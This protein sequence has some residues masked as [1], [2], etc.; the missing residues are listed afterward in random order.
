MVSRI[1]VLPLIAVGPILGTGIEIFFA[2]A[3]AISMDGGAFKCAKVALEPTSI[4]PHHEL[5]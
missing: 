2:R 5:I 1:N 3:S 4:G